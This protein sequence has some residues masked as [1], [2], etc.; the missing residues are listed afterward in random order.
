MNFILTPEEARA[1]GAL[2]E[3][4]I[5]TPEYYPLTL[6]A[7]M[8]ACNQKSNRNPVM[9]MSVDATQLAVDRL[10]QKQLAARAC[11]EGARAEKYAHLLPEVFSLS[12]GELCLL[13]ILLLRGPQTA[14]ELQD[15]H[16]RQCGGGEEGFGEAMR[17]LTE[18]EGGPLAARLPR[19]PGQ[20]E[21]RY[22]HL[23]CGEPSA[24]EPAPAAPREP[25]GD[26][27]R[28]SELERRVAALCAEVE[29]I[30]RRLEATGGSAAAPPPPANGASA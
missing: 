5:A 24:G 10:C 4:Q 19:R 22:A 21:P 2:A 18:R 16:E 7:L 9:E 28:I 12:R 25:S 14:G 1:L 15:R 23:L 11:T 29:A 13:S 8:N 26:A 30:R 3:K 20:K 17:G 6:N 27:G